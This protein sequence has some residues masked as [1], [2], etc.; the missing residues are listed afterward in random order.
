V[1]ELDE[2]HETPYRVLSPARFGPAVQLV[3]FQRSAS[4][5]SVGSY[6]SPT[7]VQ[8]LAEV[9]DT[10]CRVL[11]VAPA[12][13][14]EGSTD[15]C[16]TRGRWR[17]AQPASG[18][19]SCGTAVV[20]CSKWSRISRVRME[21]GR[22]ITLSINDSAVSGTPSARDRVDDQG[23]VAQWGQL[24]DIHHPGTAVTSLG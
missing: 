14:D 7:A 10:P 17:S 11:L 19:A 20:T 21:D 1:Q 8:K 24:D 2:V 13:L 22:E 23:R 5:C 18:R 16:F 12:G 4:A 6:W 9:H 15:H 3:P